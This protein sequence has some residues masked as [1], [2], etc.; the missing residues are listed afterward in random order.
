MSISGPQPGSADVSFI[1][2]VYPRRIVGWRPT[3][4]KTTDLIT[5]AL[6]QALATRSRADAEFTAGGL[7]HHSDAGSQGGFK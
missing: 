7:I 3:L 6:A 2:D 4:S 5:A 1:T